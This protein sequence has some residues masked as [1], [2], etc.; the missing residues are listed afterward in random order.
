MGTWYVSPLQALRVGNGERK[1]PRRVRL[2]VL[3]SIFVFIFL[4]SYW[5]LQNATYS[6]AFVTGIL[7]TFL[8]LAGLS[9]IFMKSIKLFFPSKWSFT[10]RQS[11]RNL[12]RPNNQTTTLVLAI[13]VGAFLIS[14]LYFT[15]DILLSKLT[16]DS[17]ADSPNIIMLDVQTNQ[18]DKVVRTIEPTGLPVIDNIPI[19]TMRVHEIKGRT[20]PEI[21]NDTTSNVGRWVMNHE[22]R[23][24]YRDSLIE[25]EI[26][27]EGSWTGQVQ[28]N[29][30]IPISVA[31]NFAFDAKVEVGDEV[32]FNV[33][34]VLVN[35]LIGSIR[36]VD[37]G[38][39]Q[40]NFSVVFPKGVLESAPKFHVL[41]T[42]APGR[43][44]FCKIAA[45]PCTRISQRFYN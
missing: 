32:V 17:R 33:Q 43:K 40:L 7:V 41:T 15:K 13:G 21:R 42:R 9:A 16:V 37:W 10:A 25:S 39:L 26:I 30:P 11:L 23:A 19:I 4:F 5:L 18:T 36:E 3:L 20:I 35:T 31:E 45:R 38:R 8:L 27:K 28:P 29:D 44:S 6:L 14:T 34:G 24:T 12:Y 22:F 1:K 2:L